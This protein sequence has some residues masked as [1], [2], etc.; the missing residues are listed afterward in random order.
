MWLGARETESK[1]SRK[2]QQR[3]IGGGRFKETVVG[4]QRERGRGYR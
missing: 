2:L 4:G 1:N 3:P